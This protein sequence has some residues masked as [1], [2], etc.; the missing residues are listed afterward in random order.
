MNNIGLKIK[1]R[2]C[3]HIFE[4]VPYVSLCDMYNPKA[5]REYMCKKCG[6]IVRRRS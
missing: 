2:F 6:K 1:Q 4:I 5:G 3:K